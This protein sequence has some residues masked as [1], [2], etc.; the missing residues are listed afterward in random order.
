MADTDFSNGVTLTDAAWFDDINNTAYQGIGVA[1]VSTVASA[2]TPDI[3]ATS[4]SGIIT[5]TGTTTATGFATAPRAGARRRLVCSGYA[6][7]TAGADLIIPGTESGNTY[8][9][10]PN[11]VIDVIALTTSQF[12]LA[13]KGDGLIATATASSSAALEFTNLNGFTAISFILQQVRPATNAV[14]LYM[15]VSTDNGSTYIATGYDYAL[16]AVNTTPGSGALTGSNAAQ[17]L[18]CGNPLGNTS[19]VGMTGSI[20]VAGLDSATKVKYFSIDT[21]YGNST[22]ANE[23]SAGMGV[24]STS[25]AINAVQFYMSSGNIADG[26]ISVYGIRS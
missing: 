5:Y 26:T 10:T 19:Y 25:S 16:W 4:V 15:R 12:L 22:P 21:A 11:Q 9:A 23:R 20:L 2:T 24:N 18:T 3:F 7:F 14:Y 1:G 13:V 17:I 8:T 6:P